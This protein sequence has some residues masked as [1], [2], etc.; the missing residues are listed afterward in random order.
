MRHVPPHI[1]R[2]AVTL[3]DSGPSFH[4]V[5]RRTNINRS[6]LRTWSQHRELIDKYE[7][8]GACVRCEPLPRLPD[9]QP[10]YSYLLGLYLGDGYISYVGNRT[11][12][13]W[14]LRIYCSNTW[15][16]L[17]KECVGT[18]ETVLPE[19]KIAVVDRVGCKE[20]PARWKH[21]PCLF[22]QHGPGPKHTRRIELAPWQAEVVG[23]HPE[24]FV[25]GLL[26]SDGCR[27]ANRVKR[28]AAGADTWYEY[29]RYFFS[30]ASRDIH[31]LLGRYLDQLG[32]EW[33]MSNASNLSVAKRG[34]VARLDG[35]VGPKH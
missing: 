12:Q 15:P 29:P 34:S 32:I 11:K 18:L 2:E 13:L 14:A 27:I 4:E 26:H 10:A 19:H 20:V 17:I 16:K 35:F 8:K 30:N 21:C 31:G 22:P 7:N 25:R 6:T 1:R 9:P 3:L 24:E 28:T 23:R 5:S 33:R